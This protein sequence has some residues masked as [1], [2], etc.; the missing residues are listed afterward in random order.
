L[1]GEDEITGINVNRLYARPRHARGFTLLELM[2][3]LVIFVL[4][5]AAIYGG[6]YTTRTG[7]MTDQAIKRTMGIVATIGRAYP[8]PNFT[9][10]DESK[11]IKKVPTDVV[12]PDG[13]HLMSPWG[14]FIEVAAAGTG[15]RFVITL[16]VPATECV[17]FVKALEIN[18]RALSIRGTE[19]KADGEKVDLDQVSSACGVDDSDAQIELVGV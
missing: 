10:L 17:I 13:V 12:H 14:N 9:G 16:D 15:T 19:V 1:A 3:V 6:Y 5:A 7:T 11:I 4:A 18:F 2:V 8:T